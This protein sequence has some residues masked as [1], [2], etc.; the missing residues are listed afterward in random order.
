MK[1]DKSYGYKKDF[2]QTILP[3]EYRNSIN[4]PKKADIQKEKL[5][6]NVSSN[7]STNTL[8]Q[9]WSNFCERLESPINLLDEEFENSI[10]SSCAV[11]F[12]IKNY[13]AQMIR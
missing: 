8:S 3:T 6:F 10:T 5:I 1:F 12:S 13:S 9:I 4:D 7:T 2:E 11:H